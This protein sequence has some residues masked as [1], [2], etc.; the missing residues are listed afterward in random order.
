MKHISLFS[1]IPKRKMTKGNEKSFSLPFVIFRS[2]LEV[3]FIERKQTFYRLYG[4]EH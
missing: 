1:T 4:D 2:R 3:S